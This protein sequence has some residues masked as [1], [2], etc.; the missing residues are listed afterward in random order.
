MKIAINYSSDAYFVPVR[1][2]EIEKLIKELE[3]QGW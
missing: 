2:V 1:I 3:K